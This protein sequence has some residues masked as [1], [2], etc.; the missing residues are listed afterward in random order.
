[1]ES[2]VI[3]HLVSDAAKLHSGKVVHKVELHSDFC[4]IYIVLYLC[5]PSSLSSIVVRVL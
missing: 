3:I 2:K 4:S 1:M 5:D